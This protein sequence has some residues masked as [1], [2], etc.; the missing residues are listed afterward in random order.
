MFFREETVYKSAG[1]CAAIA[2]GA[3]AMLYTGGITDAGELSKRYFLSF[4][5]ASLLSVLLLSHAVRKVRPIQTGVPFTIWPLLAMWIIS[6]VWLP[7]AEV[8]AYALNECAGWLVAACWMALA[9]ILRKMY[10]CLLAGILFGACATAFIGILQTWEW[11]TA[12][13]QVAPPAA[14]FVNRNFASH[15]AVIGLAPAIFFSLRNQ[16]NASYARL[17]TLLL[18][19]ISVYIAYTTSR[20]AILASCLLVICQLAG[21][22]LFYKE[23]ARSKRFFLALKTALLVVAGLSTGLVTSAWSPLASQSSFVEKFERL[24]VV[25]G[26]TSD[27]ENA[28][29][30][31]HGSL[32]D[33][34]ASG[35][36]LAYKSALNMLADHP[37]AGIGPGQFAVFYPLYQQSEDRSARDLTLEFLHNDYLELLVEHGLGGLVF[38]LTIAYLVVVRVFSV[39]R[40]GDA[41]ERLLAITVF[42]ALLSCL[43]M[44][45]FSGPFWKPVIPAYSAVLIGILPTAS[46]QCRYRLL[47]SPAHFRVVT[48]VIAAGLFLFGGV[49]VASYFKKLEAQQSFSAFARLKADFSSRE[50]AIEAA[51]R[52]S[53]LDPSLWKSQFHL[54]VYYEGMRK[55]KLAL[56][57]LDLQLEYFPFYYRGLCNRANLL[58]EMGRPEEAFFDAELAFRL[59]GTNEG[60]AATC[61]RLAVTNGEFDKAIHYLK[62]QVC[63]NPMNI[64]AHLA[65]VRL[66]ARENNSE[67][68]LAL[69]D[70]L[71]ER[72]RFNKHLMYLEAECSL[73]SG[74]KIRSRKVLGKLQELY[75][76]LAV[77]LDVGP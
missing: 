54:S 49:Q 72:L 26:V 34:S 64:R 46:Q 30:W 48:L 9:C 63:L 6:V 77:D 22:V 41:E 1:I 29:P 67:E 32:T 73:Q 43:V 74:D 56:E 33:R 28:A 62:Q 51:R 25:S 61:A 24:G 66:V 13:D 8:Q 52:V 37:I 68:A 3:V 50:E 17:A 53:E 11:I 40:H 21:F 75:P 60:L 35:R 71:P 12:Y 57:A 20:T 15:V 65:L 27:E 39:I 55:K 38:I 45:S 42:A 69:I 44:A 23:S 2:L 70:R 19:L 47:G 36:I 5:G 10:I 76:G 31:E 58:E 59:L 4:L 16:N 14:T 18:V 7:F